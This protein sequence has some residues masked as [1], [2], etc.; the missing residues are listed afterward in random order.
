MRSPP[1]PQRNGPLAAALVAA[2]LVAPELRAQPAPAAPVPVSATS[3][4]AE[5]PGAPPAD[6]TRVTRVVP[7][8]PS[9]SPTPAAAPA[10]PA[11][12]SSPEAPPEPSLDEPPSPGAPPRVLAELGA[13]TGVSVRVDEAPF[14]EM[15][16]RVGP[17][18]G[19]SFF[20]APSPLLS[21]GASY[22]Y[23]G[24]H[25]ARNAPTSIDVLR[26]DYAAHSLLA[27][28]RVVPVRFSSIALFVSLG[29]GLSWQSAS[30]RATI[31]PV[32]GSPGGSVACSAGS[33]AELAFRGALGMKAR[34]SRAVS[35]LVDASFIGYRHSAEVLGNCVPGAGTAQT[36]QLR[37]GF[38]YD[39][40][41]TG[42]VR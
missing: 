4:C 36:V 33:N 20:V 26:L 27:E 6:P 2:C 16:R 7:G 1:P 40:D 18:G 42:A 29:G 22:V 31:V 39:I 28:A 19:A 17:V 10:A 9:P 21:F 32:N 8:Q 34:V 35:L 30:L 41:I 24:L 23:A 25:G 37:A 14:A 15:D 13:F 3:Q 5:G 12:S 38:T 11:S